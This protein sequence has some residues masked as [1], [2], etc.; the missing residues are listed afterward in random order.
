MWIFKAFFA[1]DREYFEYD[2][3]GIQGYPAT[4]KEFPFLESLLSFSELVLAPLESLVLESC[5][6]WDR[7]FETGDRSN[8]DH[9]MAL[10]SELGQQHIYF[11]L[12]YLRCFARHSQQK[13]MPEMVENLRQLPGQLAAY[14]K[15]IQCFFD[16]VLDIDRV[17]RDTQAWMKENYYY[18]QPLSAELFA[19]RPVPVAVEAM[20]RVGYVD[21]LYPNDIR[22]LI[23]FSLR[24]C[25]RRQ[26]PVRQCKNCGRYFPL[27]VRV[28]AEYCSR[29]TASGRPCR[30]TG[31]IQ[32]WTE[33]RKEDD[34]F[35]LYRREYKRRFAWIKAGKIT[36][37]EFYRWSEVARTKKKECDSGVISLDKFKEWIKNS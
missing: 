13:L 26:M 24:E 8:S 37:E 9:A 29:P 18:N 12:E 14:Q 11:Q 28:T 20:P 22:D 36:E 34:V 21:V 17:G 6:N 2:T 7:F 32:T 31:A 33:K 25:V 4:Q 30:A 16:R 3:M 1:E 19:F 27:T 10:L 5:E 15:Q 23:D 35:Q